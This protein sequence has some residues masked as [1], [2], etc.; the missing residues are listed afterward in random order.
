[1]HNKV[2]D[3]IRQLESKTESE[4]EKMVLQKDDNGYTALHYSCLKGH[5]GCTK[6]LLKQCLNDN[7]KM[8]LLKVSDHEGFTP[9][10]IA[11]RLRKI[12]CSN[13]I[14]KSLS[15]NRLRG[16]IL[17]MKNDEGFTTLHLSC[18]LGF[19]DVVLAQLECLG[20]PDKQALILMKEK[21]GITAFHHAFR[22]KHFSC[23]KALY[24]HTN[25]TT[26]KEL[27]FCKDNKDNQIFV[28]DI[29][30]AN[31]CKFSN[32]LMELT[33]TCHQKM[34][35][36]LV[37]ACSVGC[38]FFINLLIR[39]LSK[40]KHLELLRAGP[41]GSTALHEACKCGSDMCINELMENLDE[42][43]DAKQL[44]MEQT[45]QE[46][47]ALHIAC[48]YGK[49]NCI[50]V[51]L[52]R[53]T[54]GSKVRVVQAID[55]KRR[56][57]LHVA[58][59]FG[60]DACIRT[61]LEN[62]KTSNQGLDIKEYLF[63]QDKDGW[64]GLH[65]ASFYNFPLC[66]AAQIENA[67]DDNN[68]KE[69]MV[70]QKNF[71][72]Q[73]MFHLAAQ[74]GS[75]ECITK[76]MTNI[77]R[78]TKERVIFQQDNEMKTA[79]HFACREGKSECVKAILVNLANDE[80]QHLK[81]IKVGDAT[82]NTAL[83]EACNK[84][85]SDCVRA[86][87]QDLCESQRSDVLRATNKEGST[88][89]HDACNKG[90]PD[91][92]DAILQNLPD[93][94]RQEIVQLSNQY[95]R[96]ALYSAC[97]SGSTLC[98][99]KL[100]DSLPANQKLE[101]LKKSDKRYGF[102]AL[103]AA[104]YNKHVPVIKLLLDYIPTESLDTLL[105]IEDKQGMDP[106]AISDKECKNAAIAHLW[107]KIEGKR[108]KDPSLVSHKNAANPLLPTIIRIMSK[109]DKFNL[110]SFHYSDNKEKNVKILD[111]CMNTS[112]NI[113]QELEKC[114]P[115]FSEYQQKNTQ[116]PIV[117]RAHPLKVISETKDIVLIKHPYIQLY[118]D[119]CWKAFIRKVLFGYIGIYLLFFAIYCSFVLG[120]Q[121]EKSKVT[122]HTNETPSENPQTI[123]TVLQMEGSYILPRFYEELFRWLTII[124]SVLSLLLELFQMKTKGISYFLPHNGD[125]LCI[126]NYADLAITI[127]AILVTTLSLKIGY[128]W[129]IH[130]IGC[131]SLIIGT[132]RA[133]WTLTNVPVIGEKYFMLLSGIWNVLKFTPVLVPFL[134][135]FA[136]LFQNIMCYQ[137]PFQTV[138]LSFL[139][140]MIL[141]IGE[142]EFKDTF[143]GNSDVT[144]FEILPPLILIIFL[145]IVTISM[146]NLL[147]GVAV[148][149]INELTQQGEQS[150]FNSK[151]DLIMQ[152][153]HMFPF[154]SDIFHKKSIIELR[155]I[156]LQHSEWKESNKR[157]QKEKYEREV[158]EMRS[159]L[160]EDFTDSYRVCI[161][162]MDVR[163]LRQEF[164]EQL[165]EV[166]GK[167]EGI[168]NDENNP[169]IGNDLHQRQPN[170][171]F[172]YLQNKIDRMD[173][174]NSTLSEAKHTETLNSVL[175]S[176]HD[177]KIG[178]ENILREIR[179]LSMISQEGS[180]RKI[181][182]R[183]MKRKTVK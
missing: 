139:K 99:K 92:V 127:K 73:T 113:D 89:L 103:H 2:D 22:G 163:F 159:S 157:W 85:D 36:V 63:A 17:T 61:L 116:F 155:G 142:I 91:C 40:E 29:Y 137:D 37:H 179:N 56:T 88:A 50:K 79:L 140:T 174:V 55:E 114:F 74:R 182:P 11:T 31:K 148:G 97:W 19:D 41:N 18:Y 87:F 124:L 45:C 16:Q 145:I 173:S 168:K 180:K 161:S 60:N 183:G 132:L 164:N 176:L 81:L 141:S 108:E 150:I 131:L 172:E 170:E 158:N 51:M 123:F 3:I 4:K 134:L 143:P 95:G 105:S 118:V 57:A 24:K 166:V 86:I 152:Y 171:Q 48:Q 122:T 162:E 21:N 135:I 107:S 125:W 49:T 98:I 181:G 35:P 82:G 93:S 69:T 23:I 130:I 26:L 43:E 121:F 8:K 120:H 78:Q 76:V 47:T 12:E 15:M 5:D 136:L 109:R 146:M 169:K 128:N 110:S 117:C 38:P 33:D 59:Q 154:V 149:N 34:W 42:E 20:N 115:A 133:S 14:L 165:I 111:S 77:P 52:G 53:L 25:E 160:F 80:K 70:A 10:Q 104:F 83:H 112:E 64:T 9:L 44:I 68:V 71:D 90:D 94:Q 144:F 32:V 138:W 30:M 129:W 147:I 106:I 151:V 178:Q 101:M 65:F 46:E 7:I 6:A 62:I 1:M 75:H 102:T 167:H 156:K 175:Q 72:E 153:C 100:L 39:N 58:S 177:L 126:E 54:E 28:Q 66:I 119:T 13:A 84:G 27:I 67:P 96:T